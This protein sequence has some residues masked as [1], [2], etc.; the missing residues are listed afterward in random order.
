MYESC[1][2]TYIV[3][4]FIAMFV[5]I[6][7]DDIKAKETIKYFITSIAILILGIIIYYI[8]GKITLII[9]ERLNIL[10]E[11]H[12]Y[13][14][15]L[16]LE[17]EFAEA[18]LKSKLFIIDILVLKPFSI[19]TGYLPI[20][21]FMSFSFISIILECI[22][23]LKENKKSR[24]VS[25]LGIILSN[26]ILA[27]L[28]VNVLYRMQ[29]SIIITTAFLAMYIYQTLQSKKIIKYIVTAFFI[30]I[31]I[32]QTS[33][34]NQY[35]YNDYKRY[36]KE[37]TIAND[38][39][40]NVMKTCN[41]KEK[42]ILCY[43]PGGEERIKEIYKINSDNGN[44]V[45]KWGMSAFGEIQTELTKFINEQGYNFKYIT[46]EEAIKAYEELNELYKKNDS[47]AN[48]PILELENVIAI[49]LEYYEF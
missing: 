10:H 13:S 28:L 14:I 1:A 31:I 12:A 2:Q 27:F 6:I 11:N 20:I 5:K 17:K 34:L 23:L 38:I 41:Y 18:N 35:F 43:M 39:A 15:V 9:L 3:F 32:I 49:N 22:N 47:R 30:W 33:S 19:K 4:T 26:F 42:P 40:I 25:I 8:T 7:S 29:F 48:S 24:L 21:T 37:K 44:S 16:W 36:E 46:E 45:I